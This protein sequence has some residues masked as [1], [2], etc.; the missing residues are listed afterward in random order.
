MRELRFD[1]LLL[2]QKRRVAGIGRVPEFGVSRFGGGEAA[3]RLGKAVLRCRKATLDFIPARDER[4]VFGGGGFAK[5]PER[6]GR[7]MKLLF[8]RGFSS[9]KS[10]PLIR[11][12]AQSFVELSLCRREFLHGLRELAFEFR[13]RAASQPCLRERT[14]CI[15]QIPLQFGLAGNKSGDLPPE[16]F[17]GF[18]KR[19]LQG[20]K[21]LFKFTL[22]CG[23]R[24][25]F[26]PRRTAQ[27]GERVLRV[28]QLALQF[29]TRS[30]EARLPF[31]ELPPCVGEFTV[32]RIEFLLGLIQQASGLRQALFQS[33]LRFR[34]L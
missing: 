16:V 4:R 27:L 2:A 7:R 21:L 1:V 11:R 23:E 10:H 26:F 24:R 14:V 20:R 34:K 32:R 3:L 22:G 15:L 13:L 12:G 6:L 17:P 18:G 33:G 29:G 9:G 19:S 31:A 25:D 5:L 28:I 8:Q 30:R